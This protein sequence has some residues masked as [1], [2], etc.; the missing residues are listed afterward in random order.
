MTP[1]NTEA[2]PP[3]PPVFCCQLRVRPLVHLCLRHRE[4][5]S[6]LWALQEPHP[7]QQAGCSTAVTE[8]G[9]VQ[10]GPWVPVLGGRLWLANNFR[11]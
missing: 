2:Q 11:F 5:L 9:Y 7:R 6:V 4:E 10:G 1:L 3:P 8:A